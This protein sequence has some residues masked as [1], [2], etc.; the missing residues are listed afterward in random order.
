MNEQC[1]ILSNNYQVKII[2]CP[3]FK[4]DH[5]GC[6]DP[7]AANS[8]DPQ[9]YCP[10]DECC[11]HSHGGAVSAIQAC[12]AGVP[13]VPEQKMTPN[14]NACSEG[15]VI[16]VDSRSMS[17]EIFLTGVPFPIVYSSEKV[18]GRKTWFNLVIPP[19]FSEANNS[20]LLREDI[21]IEI[22][23]RI[24]LHQRLKLNSDQDYL[25]VW[26]E[27]NSN[28]QPVI[29]SLN[30]K[31]TS[32]PIYSE[33]GG[34][35]AG[36][37]VVANLVIGT[38]LIKDIGFAGW[39][40]SVRHQYD[41]LRKVVYF[42]DGNTMNATAISRSN[43][44][45]WVIS[46]DRSEIFVFDQNY[47]H[48]HTR[49]ALTNATILIFNYNAQGK[50][51]S[52]VDAYGNTTSIQ[53]NGS[54]PISITSPYGQV[55]NLTLDP[56]GYLASVTSP[57]SEI[58]QMSYNSSGLLESFTKPSGKVS[59][60]SY[61]SDGLIV[62][63]GLNGLLKFIGPSSSLPNTLTETS[64]LSRETNHE[65][66]V[67]KI[68]FRRS[69]TYP[70]FSTTVYQEDLTTQ[71]YTIERN[72]S[73][74]SVTKS[75]DIRFGQDQKIID[76]TSLYNGGV[77]FITY[78][79]ESAPLSDSSDPF[80]F[81]SLSV[82]S[83]VNDNVFT[84]IF[85]PILKQWTYTSPAGRISSKSIDAQGKP[86]TYQMAG[87]T[88]VNFSYDN[89]GRL[90]TLT[91]GPNRKTQFTY[92]SNSGLVSTIQ[93]ALNQTTSFTHDSSGRLASQTLADGRVILY[94]YDSNDNLVSITPPGKLVHSLSYNNFELLTS[95]IPPT[96][97]APMPFTTTYSYNNEKELTGIQRPDGQNIQFNYSFEGLMD[98]I[99][100][101]TGL[102]TFGYS[103]GMVNS[104]ISED[105]F[106]R[107]IF[108]AGSL[109]SYETL[110][111]SDMSYSISYAYNSDHLL[112]N[113]SMGN[114]S[115]IHSYDID[116]LLLNAGSQSFTR[117]STTGLI[118]QMNLGNI[119]QNFSYSSSYGELSEIHAS[120]NG[121]DIF[122]ETIT[123][124]NLGRVSAKAEQYS[125]GKINQYGY[126]YDVTGRL[127]AVTLNGSPYSS[128]VY[129]SNSNRIE[130]TVQGNTQSGIIYD[131]QDRLITFGPKSFSYNENGDLTA[132]TIPS[133]SQ[134][135]SFY[136][137]V[138][139]NL[140]SVILPTKTI[141]YGVDAHNRRMVKK[142]NTLVENYFL[143]GKD[144]QLLAVMNASG[145][146]TSSFVYGSKPHVP[147]YM[148]KDSVEYQII[149]NHLGSPVVVIDASTGTIA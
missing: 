101:A 119:S 54:S 21:K 51:I 142:V 121:S 79:N 32:T 59:T 95:Y 14:Q 49:S 71:N 98:S 146:V 25:L 50:L 46:S 128:Y 60:K 77:Y 69:T 131:D 27:L 87:F 106:S 138:F 73:R 63:S 84:S 97:L 123:R 92:N 100:F 116:S 8:D 145:A 56:N 118:T 16:R 33:S 130:Q 9:L 76:S 48:I 137:D 82:N 45:H 39:D 64:V 70:D 105:S 83:T 102:R 34:S 115:I 124:D 114:Q 104:S 125:G 15:S 135:S 55:T 134:T 127:T 65:F 109:I 12:P 68:N 19:L 147:D 57:A 78:I 41:P 103:Q 89:H 81:S 4:E 6:V 110:S 29:G 72:A 47:K 31:V 7:V 74:F 75:D 113:L 93:N 149:S 62:N 5:W 126:T 111:N 85:N 122:K 20:S 132:V 140:K 67:N 37:P 136:Y 35:F 24:F 112:Y 94:T 80:S 107:N 66:E 86:L 30:A 52:V 43:G 117:S 40:F 143:W 139:G 28:N 18:S 1:E 42:G 10:S 120:H 141:E 129:D 26:D 2:Y 148:I 88:P 53:Y 90:E 91:Q 99:T 38:S 17:E 144:N 13:K 44:E 22:S 58:Y 23:D 3:Q 11:F 108:Y 61:N 96:I 133:V 36:N